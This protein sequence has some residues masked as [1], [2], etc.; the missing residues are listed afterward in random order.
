MYDISTTLASWMMILYIVAMTMTMPLTSLIVDRLGRKQ[1]Y[2]LG[3]GLFGLF[4]ILGGLCYQYVQVVLLV[5]FMHGVAAGIMIPLSLVLLFD[6]YEPE[7]RGKVTGVWGMLLTIATVIGPT[8]G[9]VIIQVGELKHLFWLNVSLC[10]FVIG[11][12]H[13]SNPILCSFEKKKPSFPRNHLDHLQYCVTKLRYSILLQ[14][15]HF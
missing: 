3:I 15:D 8:L 2:L 5:R 9:G 4:S 6:F 11:M 10:S 7:V 12:V 1:T 14:S 13:H